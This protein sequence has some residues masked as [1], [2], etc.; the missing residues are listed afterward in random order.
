MKTHDFPGHVSLNKTK[1]YL[2][3]AVV[4]VLLVVHNVGV[5]VVGGELSAH[6]L[7]EET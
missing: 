1:T 3:D 4:D 2:S 6:G 7:Q 5:R